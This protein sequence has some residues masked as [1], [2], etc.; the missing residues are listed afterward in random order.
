[1]ISEDTPYDPMENLRGL[2][3]LYPDFES[4]LARPGFKTQYPQIK[5]FCG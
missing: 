3:A 5:A 1:M 2:R 4:Y